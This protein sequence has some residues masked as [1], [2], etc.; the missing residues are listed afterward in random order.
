MPLVRTCF[1][2]EPDRLSASRQ[3]PL[4]AVRVGV[5]A[6]PRRRVHPADRGYRRRAL[7]A[8]SRAERSSTRWRGSVSTTTRGRTSRRSGWTATAPCSPIMLA[9]GLAYR[10]Y[11]STSEEL[12]PAR[13]ADRARRKAALRRPLAARERQREDA[14][15][16]RA[17]GDPL[18]QS[19]RAASSAWDDAVKGADRDRQRGARR[20]RALR[21]PTARRPTTSASSSTTSTCGSRTSSAATTTSTIRRARSTSCTRSARAARLRAPADR[22]DARRRASCRSATARAACCSTATTAI[23]PMPWS[24]I[25]RVSAGRT[26]T[27]KCFRAKQLVA[28]FDLGGPDAVAG[29]LRSGQAQ[30]AEPRASSSGCRTTNSARAW[31]RS[32]SS[33]GLDWRGGPPCRGGRRRCC[34]TVRRRLVEMADAA[35]YFY[36][37]PRTDVPAISCRAAMTDASRPS[38]DAA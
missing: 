29:P 25:S 22:A 3:H 37:T 35:H 11:M 21:A 24:T 33:A 23:S 32:S 31:R 10:D 18:S 15:A 36:A 6:R 26:A 2:A 38:A 13:C 30:V 16:G 1:R 27:T 34:A 17:A 12:T 4:R 28:W 9:R 7:D 8:R 19:G 5:R 20:P 14:A